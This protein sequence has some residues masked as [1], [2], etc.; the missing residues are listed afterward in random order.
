LQTANSFSAILCFSDIL[1][2][3]AIQILNRSLPNWERHILIA[4]FDNIKETFPVPIVFPS[5]G[6][7][8]ISMAETAAITL[9]E[10]MGDSSRHD[11]DVAY[12][13]IQLSTQLFV[14]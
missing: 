1:A 13:E 5:V 2:L 8:G 4:G 12:R 11:G 3:Q 14:K 10:I 6:T 7:S 9:I